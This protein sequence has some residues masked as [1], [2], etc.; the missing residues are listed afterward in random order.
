ML[1][2][3]FNHSENGNTGVIVYCHKIAGKDTLP[4]SILPI[5]PCLTLE[6]RICLEYKCKSLIR[7]CVEMG[8]GDS[9]F[10]INHTLHFS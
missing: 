3:S 9:Q 1:C 6:Q 10:I 5:L 8:N 4:C 7:I 2:Y